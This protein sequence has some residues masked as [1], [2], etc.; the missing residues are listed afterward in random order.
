MLNPT[1]M[2]ARRSLGLQ[3]WF[4]ND[5]ESDM[6]I[7]QQLELIACSFLMPACIWQCR[8]INGALLARRKGMYFLK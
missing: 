7:M 2:K 8:E 6:R 4:E 1:R 3:M 5:I